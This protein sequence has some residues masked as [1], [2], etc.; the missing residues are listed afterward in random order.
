MAEKDGRSYRCSIPAEWALKEAISSV[1]TSSFWSNSSS[2]Y[3]F[4]KDIIVNS[5]VYINRSYVI[6]YYYPERELLND[7]FRW[8]NNKLKLRNT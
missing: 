6:S 7:G 3:Y 8:T 4:I 5:F 2:N 1:Q